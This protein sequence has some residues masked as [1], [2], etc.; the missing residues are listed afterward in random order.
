M[1]QLA[2]FD[3]VNL[4]NEVRRKAEK[5]I[6]SYRKINALIQTL[7]MELPNI[8]LTPSYELKEGSCSGVSN[9]IESMYLKQEKIREEVAK[10]EL[11]KHKL[12]IIY[13]SLN[14]IQKTIWE[15]RYI[16]GRFDEA[17]M[18]ILKIRRENYYEQKN[19]IIKLVAKAFCLV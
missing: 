17:V 2:L 16:Y 7:Q 9:T 3:E 14:D 18:N 10:N 5:I 19:D 12:D 15:H 8:K 1:E 11:I 6:S 13:D 4:T